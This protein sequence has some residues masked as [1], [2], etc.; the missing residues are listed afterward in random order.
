M[1]RFRY[2]TASHPGLVRDTNEDAG[3]A[4]DHLLVVADGVGGAPAG[5]VA[6]ANATSVVRRIASTS[7]GDPLT[8]LVQ[9]VDCSGQQLR[10]G[11]NQMP[12]RHGMA[13]TL[14]AI[15][16]DGERF[17]L[18]HL[19]D[20]RAFLLRDGRCD[21]ITTDHTLVQLMID[22]GQ[23]T[24]DEAAAMPFQAVIAK[25]LTADSVADPDL[26]EL[27]LSAGDRMLLA[28]DGLT[29][30]LE[31]DAI[32]Q[33]VAD[34]DLESSVEQLLAHAL[35][36]GGRDN[37]TL[38]LGEVVDDTC[39]HTSGE[40]IGAARDPD[41]LI[42]DSDART[43]VEDP[44]PRAVLDPPTAEGHRQGWRKSRAG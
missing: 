12:S 38:V 20:S 16:T 29:D 10:S 42:D 19:G 13:T 14:T 9:A 26:I 3:Y 35:S 5:E 37:I 1:L 32:P 34:H 21:Q 43:T 6:S 8:V 40:L 30:T 17:G 36:A 33:L 18:A 39:G 28:S 7:D 27:N 44:G 4:G 15:L 25:S 23:L 24:A 22:T 41:N 31:T 11:V 2:A